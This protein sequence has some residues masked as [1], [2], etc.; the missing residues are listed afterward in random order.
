M[1]RRFRAS[2]SFITGLAE[3]RTVVGMKISTSNMAVFVE[4]ARTAQRA[5]FAMIAGDETVYPFTLLLGGTGVIGQGCTT[6]PEIHRAIYECVMSQDLLGASR[7]ALDNLEAA[8]SARGES[9]VSLVFGYLAL[10]GVRVQ[11]YAMSGGAPESEDVLSR[12]QSKIDAIRAPYLDSI[13]R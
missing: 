13:I 3:M 6:H 7:A 12:F 10:K 1:A 5:N 9:L 4:A 2:P 8:R 11:P